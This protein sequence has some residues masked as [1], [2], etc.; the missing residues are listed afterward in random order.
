MS[1]VIKTCDDT[2][3]YNHKCVTA[4]IG[5]WLTTTPNPNRTRTYAGDDGVTGWK[6]HFIPVDSLGKSLCGISA[7]HGWGGDAFIE[8]QCFRCSEAVFKM[9]G[10]QIMTNKEPHTHYT[11][12]HCDTKKLFFAGSQYEEVFTEANCAKPD[13]MYFI[14]EWYGIDNGQDEIIEQMSV[15]E[16]LRDAHREV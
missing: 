16:W 14:T 2:A 5:E 6:L 8:D 15:E 4:M 7:K 1:E 13:S 10:V 11:I 3:H 9:G 12:T